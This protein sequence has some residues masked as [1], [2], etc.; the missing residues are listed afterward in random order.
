MTNIQATLYHLT[1]DW[2]HQRWTQR[3]TNECIKPYEG[4]KVLQT[5]SS[6]MGR[7]LIVWIS[8][9][10]DTKSPNIG[11][12]VSSMCIQTPNIVTLASHS[13]SKHPWP[14]RKDTIF[15]IR[16]KSTTK[17]PKITIKVSNM[18]IQANTTC[19]LVSHTKPKELASMVTKDWSF[20]TLNANQL[21]HPDLY[22][23]GPHKWTQPT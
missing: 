15:C 14:Q 7:D 8:T 11:H 12:K 19:T 1:C 4:H 5:S 22:S 3:L 9:Y 18:C 17:G 21:R 6:Y 2:V 16:T 20:N 23:S 13:K 10:Y